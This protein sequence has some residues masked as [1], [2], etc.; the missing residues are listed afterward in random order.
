MTPVIDAVTMTNNQYYFLLTCFDFTGEAGSKDEHNHNH[1]RVVSAQKK[2]EV[3][4]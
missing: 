2:P 1:V 4:K 3:L